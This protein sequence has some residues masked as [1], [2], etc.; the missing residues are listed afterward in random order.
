MELEKR[1]RSSVTVKLG[2]MKSSSCVFFILF[3]LSYSEDFL[4]YEFEAF[5]KYL[6][7]E[8]RTSTVS[9]YSL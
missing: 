3:F 4:V 8:Q 2:K 6:K 9:Q 7:A 1:N 5:K